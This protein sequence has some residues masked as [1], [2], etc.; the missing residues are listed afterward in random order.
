ME[1]IEALRMELRKMLDDP[2][3]GVK[4]LIKLERSA[5]AGRAFL[6]TLSGKVGDVVVGGQTIE[7]DPDAE[8]TLES[9]L[10]VNTAVGPVGLPSPS[11]G[12]IAPAPFMETG[13]AAMIREL[14]KLVPQMIAGKDGSKAES[15]TN[16]IDALAVARSQGMTD[17]AAELE[18]KIVG[19]SL[20]GDRPVGYARVVSENN[21]KVEEV[22]P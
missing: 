2:G 3:F 14:V 17:V 16:L 15:L 5:R 1:F 7:N 21:S 12:P 13:G 11:F 9:G 20:D 22:T 8:E 4:S 10:A 19:K 6:I 18:K